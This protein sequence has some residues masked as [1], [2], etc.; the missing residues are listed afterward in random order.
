MKVTSIIAS[1]LI[2]LSAA[3][4]VALASSPIA[5]F[6]VN[7]NETYIGSIAYR[8]GLME[9]GELRLNQAQELKYLRFD[10]PSFCKGE[11]FEAGTI[12][13]G[14]AD[15]AEE[16][17]TNYFSVNGGRGMRAGKVFVS[18]N[19]PQSEGCNILVFKLAKA[20]GHDP[21]PP[22]T[23]QKAYTCVTNQSIY[24]IA[25]QIQTPGSTQSFSLVPNQTIIINRPGNMTDPVSLVFDQDLTNGYQAVSVRVEG[26]IQ[27]RGDC[28][29]APSYSFLE[30]QL[31]RKLIV[32]RNH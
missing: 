17:K 6:E 14:V 25:G 19:G 29:Q 27:A 8:G 15:V 22:P 16:L 20:P 7:A 31:N 30:D 11:I 2:A 12:T 13:E 5:N 26:K 23:N 3:S 9:R 1:T 10:I 18:V 21:L 24:S 4:S 28:S 32:V